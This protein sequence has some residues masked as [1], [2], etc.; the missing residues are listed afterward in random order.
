MEIIGF[1][2]VQITPPLYQQ[3]GLEKFIYTERQEA[4]DALIS[5]FNKLDMLFEMKE[6]SDRI[7]FVN[8]AGSKLAVII[9]IPILER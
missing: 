8:E 1:R 5:G 2:I 7:V 6:E 3:M 4:I 9:Q